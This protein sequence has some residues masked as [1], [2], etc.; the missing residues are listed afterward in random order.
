[1]IRRLIHL[2]D[3]EAAIRR[4][5]GFMLEIAG[6]T[7]K[8]YPS[9]IAFLETICATHIQAGCILLDIRMPDMDGLE[10]QAVLAERGITLPIIVLTGHGDV[11]VAAKAMRAGAVDFLEKPFKKTALLAAIGEGFARAD[12]IPSR[13]AC[14]FELQAR[15]AA[16]SARERHVLLSLT[17]G[18]TNQ[19][20]AD[21]LGI[22][23]GGAE[24]LRAN[25]M[26]KLEVS[27]LSDLLRIVF[28]SGLGDCLPEG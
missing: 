14:S 10:V 24:L 1:M 27:S 19:V 11:S 20:I 22:S 21:N 8:S 6:F 5:A 23:A 12:N 16:L 4:S 25:L 2:V 28:T 7:V 15:I 17:A 13:S 9:G 3:D 26:T 18:L